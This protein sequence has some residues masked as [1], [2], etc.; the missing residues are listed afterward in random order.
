M[1]RFLF[2][3]LEPI[4]ASDTF[5]ESDWKI[6]RDMVDGM[7]AIRVLTGY[8]A[9][10]GKFDPQVRAYWFDSND[11]LVKTYFAGV[12]TRRSDFQS[13]DKVNIAHH[14]DVGSKGALAM[15]IQVTDVSPA[16][17]TVPKDFQIKGHEYRR[18]FTDEMR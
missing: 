6:T 7:N 18:A 17:A 8:E 10:D 14:I 1:L 12:E 3:A 5:V 2:R 11:N 9:P 15:L 16:G 4:P 13:F